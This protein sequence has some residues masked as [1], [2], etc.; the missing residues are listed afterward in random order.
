MLILEQTE[1]RLYHLSKLHY[2]ECVIRIVTALHSSGFAWMDVKP[3]NVVAVHTLTGATSLVGIDLDHALLLRTPVPADQEVTWEYAPPEFV[4]LSETNDQRYGLNS[5]QYDIW[6]L[7]I[8]AMEIYDDGQSLCS[9]VTDVKSY[10]RAL[11][12]EDIDRYIDSRFNGYHK[13]G[14][15][16]FLKSTL[17]LNPTL[18]PRA[19]TLITILYGTNLTGITD[20]KRDV[21]RVV[22]TVDEVK[23]TTDKTGHEVASVNAVIHEVRTSFELLRGDIRE[24]TNSIKNA[25]SVSTSGLMKQHTDMLDSLEL[26]HLQTERVVALANGAATAEDLQGAVSTIKSD[27]LAWLG[28]SIGSFPELREVLEV[29]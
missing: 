19:N 29:R 3:A 9:I 11:T 27:V 17:Q 15:R 21:Q 24:S 7:G 28:E 25:L 18:R 23:E 14:I 16:H 20:L 5:E 1:G 22:A 26:L 12:Q 8:T 6:S 13:R 4:Q 10:L 2:I